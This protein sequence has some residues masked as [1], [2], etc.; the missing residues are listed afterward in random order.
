MSFAAEN[1]RLQN[2]VS[3]APTS[4]LWNNGFLLGLLPGIIDKGLLTRSRDN[5]IA[6]VSPESHHSAVMICT[7]CLSLHNLMHQSLHPCNTLFSFMM[8]VRTPQE[9]SKFC[10]SRKTCNLFFW[11]FLYHLDLVR[12]PTPSVWREYIILRHMPK[13]KAR[14]QHPAS[15]SITWSPK[16]N[17]ASWFV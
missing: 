11:P 10:F 17:L 14:G 13:N 5:W 9:S 7:E 15:S 4:S 8:W 16:W 1:E 2:K 12:L 6:G 3:I